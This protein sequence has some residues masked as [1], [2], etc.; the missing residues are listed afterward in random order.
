MVSQKTGKLVKKTD[1]KVISMLEID[2]Y[3]W[4]HFKEESIIFPDN[5]RKT[6]ILD[7]MHDPEEIRN[8]VIE[9]QKFKTIFAKKSQALYPIDFT[10]DFDKGRFE[11]YKRRR[12]SFMDEEEVM[13][14]ELAEL[15]HDGRVQ[16]FDVS[17]EKI[18]Q[19][20]SPQSHENTKDQDLPVNASKQEEEK[21]VPKENLA[22][23]ENIFIETDVEKIH[24]KAHE[25]GFEQGKKD[26]YEQ[27]MQEGHQ[28]G[29]EQGYQ[30]AAAL[31]FQ[32]GEERGMCAAESKYELAF[33][34]IAKASLKMSHLKNILLNEGKE[35]F[36]EI[37]KLCSEKILHEKLKISDHILFHLFD[38][39]LKSYDSKTSLNIEMN[40]EDAQK[41]KKYLSLKEENLKVEIKENNDLE[42]GNF[43]VE[44]ETRV[45]LLDLKKNIVDIVENLKSD[46]FKNY[47]NDSENDEKKPKK[48][49]A[50]S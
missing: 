24:L 21:T 16:D 18:K 43:N 25:Q 1:K 10:N 4:L 39:I 5:P 15:E 36:V 8:K 49:K 47:E 42:T 28:K 20:S 17:K 19:S 32:S 13:A 40:H 48:N 34:Q 26:G 11:A 29:Y 45:S 3:P 33:Q 6:V 22:K 35:I 31:G 12:R 2:S 23:E 38:E 14:L 50:V 41:I 27:G 37:L 7:K 30:E 9:P 44:N 46:L